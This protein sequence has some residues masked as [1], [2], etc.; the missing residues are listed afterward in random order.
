MS[1]PECRV[2]KLSETAGDETELTKLCWK[3]AW[4]VRASIFFSLSFIAII[5]LGL[6]FAVSLIVKYIMEDAGFYT[7]IMDYV[8]Q[9]NLENKTTLT[10]P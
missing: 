10:F 8:N 6:I 5:D 3:Y 7:D 4:F 2:S 9:T 1:Q